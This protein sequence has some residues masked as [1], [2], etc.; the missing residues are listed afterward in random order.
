MIQP[1]ALV[2][3]LIVL[4]SGLASIAGAWAVRRWLALP[5]AAG[6]GDGASAIYSMVGVVYAVLLAFV[7]VVVWQQYTDTDSDLQQ[8]AVRLAN[9]LR[10]S[11][12]FAEP[13]GREL[14][15]SLLD[16]TAA[17][18]HEEWKTLAK[19]EESPAA[20][21]AYERVW[22]AYYAI[23]PASERERVF[24][25]ES[26]NRLNEL[27]ASRRARLTSSRS[28]LPGVLWVLLVAGGVVVMAFT[29][30]LGARSP[31]VQAFMVGSL[32]GL[33][34]FVLFL[35]LCLD[36]PFSGDLRLE[37]TAFQELLRLWRPGGA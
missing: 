36:Y 11:R 30:L 18:A 34:G 9:L 32:G 28:G 8:E 3:A 2:G 31:G 27:A 26:V 13:R 12:A 19:G 33:I 21:A 37:P 29:Y 20:S 16:Y 4:F 17:I 22:Q 10:D 24:Y 23:E 15:D 1:D 5:A 35:I 25:R 7:V 6:E 14:R